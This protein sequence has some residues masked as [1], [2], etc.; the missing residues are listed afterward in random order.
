M[1]IRARSGRAFSARCWIYP[2]NRAGPLPSENGGISDVDDSWRGGVVRNMMPT[3]EGNLLLAESGL[4]M[5]ALVEIA[6]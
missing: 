3:R 1:A 6:K 4:N 5:V 2:S